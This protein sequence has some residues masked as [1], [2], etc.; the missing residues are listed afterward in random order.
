MWVGVFIKSYMGDSLDKEIGKS[1]TVLFHVMSV[2]LKSAVIFHTPTSGK[3]TLNLPPT[4]HPS[5]ALTS[6]RVATS[7]REPYTLGCLFCQLL[8]QWCVHCW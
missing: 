7:T 2:H 5:P 1:H 4:P 8:E 6:R 3:Q